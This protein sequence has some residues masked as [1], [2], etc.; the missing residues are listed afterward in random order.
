M[1]NKRDSKQSKTS[2]NA[3]VKATHFSLTNNCGLWVLSTRA[4]DIELV[5]LKKER[6]IYCLYDTYSEACP[7]QRLSR[8]QLW[9]SCLSQ[10]K[11]W[12]SDWLYLIGDDSH[13]CLFGV[14]LLIT[15]VPPSPA[16]GKTIGYIGRVC[17]PLFSWLLVSWDNRGFVHDITSCKYCNVFSKKSSLWSTHAK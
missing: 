12:L 11:L 7:N 1:E 15:Y 17:E 9:P 14:C 3:Q 2:T 5:R 16:Q 10:L 6:R 4:T 13:I 8:S